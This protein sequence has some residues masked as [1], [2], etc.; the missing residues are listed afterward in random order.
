ML[1]SIG[2]LAGNAMPTPDVTPQYLRGRR[3]LVLEDEYWVAN[4]LA[5]ALK[6][7]GAEVIGPAPDARA[8]F[9]LLT[10]NR[11]IDGAVLDINLNGE[12]DY[13]IADTLA[14]RGVPFGFATGYEAA[15]L[16]RRYRNV[17]HWEKPFD[18]AEVVSAVAT[19]IAADA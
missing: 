6:D 16:P 10:K 18:M 14:A 5:Q 2:G 19:M 3:V 4:Y 11:Q 15:G 7:A 1:G 13:Q 9:E 8:A 12:R 17:P